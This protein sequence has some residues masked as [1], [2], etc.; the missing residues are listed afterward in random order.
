MP[1]SSMGGHSFIH[2]HSHELLQM[3]SGQM[4]DTPNDFMGPP[5]YF[6]CV[7]PGTFRL[8]GEGWLMAQGC[9]GNC[10]GPLQGGDR[11]YAVAVQC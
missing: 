1:C 10:L 3:P 4:L 8:L 11:D 2:L 5:Y 7:K 9:D 6:V